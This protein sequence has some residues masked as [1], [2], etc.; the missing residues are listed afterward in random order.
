MSGGVPP[1]HHMPMD[2]GAYFG[3]PEL[4]LRFSDSH[5]LLVCSGCGITTLLAKPA[6]PF[7]GGGFR[8]TFAVDLLAPQI[9]PVWALAW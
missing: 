7:C 1:T 8:E 6:C 3:R 5:A 2:D 4:H 9:E